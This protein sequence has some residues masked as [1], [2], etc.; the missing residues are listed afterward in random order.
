MKEGK[1]IM[2]DN[3]TY[4][5]NGVCSR[6][7]DIEIEDGVIVGVTLF[8]ATLSVVSIILGDVLMSLV[9]PRISFTS[10]RR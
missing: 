6:K 5:T 7:I 10:K 9:D 3:I 4:N 8:Y 2:I 1:I